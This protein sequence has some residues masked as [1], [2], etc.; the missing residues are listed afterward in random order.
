MKRDGRCFYT[1]YDGTDIGNIQELNVCKDRSKNKA[2]N[3]L[4]GL[5]GAYFDDGYA[6][7]SNVGIHS[8]QGNL[9]ILEKSRNTFENEMHQLS[10]FDKVDP[11]AVD[12]ENK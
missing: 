12:A 10:D 3:C 7:I 4:S 2:E 8:G 1:A 6:I 11:K 9:G 5:G